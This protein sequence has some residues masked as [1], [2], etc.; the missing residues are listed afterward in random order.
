LRTLIAGLAGIA[1]FEFPKLPKIV[2]GGYRA[3]APPPFLQQFQ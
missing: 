1:L 2:A 3:P